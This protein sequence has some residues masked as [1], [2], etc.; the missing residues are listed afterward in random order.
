[1]PEL[2]RTPSHR[3]FSFTV[4]TD[5]ARK[6]NEFFRDA[7]R[8]QW[9]AG[10]LGVLIIIA[11]VLMNIIYSVSGLSIVVSIVLIILA[12]GCFALIPILPRTMG[13][14][15][16]YYDSYGLVPAVIVK[17]NPRDLV[18]MALVDAG[19]E[20]LSDSIPALVTRTVTS[21][22][23]VER[24]EGA[25]VPSVAVTGMRS[26]RNQKQWGHIS[27]MPIAW[28]TQDIEV[29]RRAEKEIPGRHWKK[30]EKY[31]DRYEEVSSAENNILILSQ[32]S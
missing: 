11:T 26:V 20:G 27:P 10:I 29:W 1:M 7:T 18:I 22:P 24:R 28:G 16:S 8:F 14:P 19:V 13:S 9:S 21:I 25:H 5:Y 32:E 6:H 23:G 3:E 30:L 4:D 15:Q 12:L 2:P 17:V 31:M